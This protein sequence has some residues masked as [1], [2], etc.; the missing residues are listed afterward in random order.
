VTFANRRELALSEQLDENTRLLVWLGVLAVAGVV[1]AIAPLVGALL[2]A[3]ILLGFAVTARS[4]SY[5]A[6]AATVLMLVPLLRLLWVTVP[7]AGVPELDWTLLIAAP[8]AVATNVVARALGVTPQD[9][10]MRRPS[11]PLIEV[12]VVAGLAAAGLVIGLV[13][14]DLVAWGVTDTDRFSIRVI[15][16]A[17]LIAYAEE[18][19]FRGVMPHVLERYAPG[20][21][22]AL[23]GVAY[24]ILALGS[25]SPLWALITVGLAIVTT[26][27]VRRSGSLWGVMAGHAA[28]L[29]L[30]TI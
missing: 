25:G 19:A 8:F 12:L 2:D 9:V 21:G 16:Y 5:W 17:L 4:R 23:A 26:L 27:A 1:G 22:F 13:A 11:D 18:L 10:G 15:P 3:L 24:V 29:I 28:F 6:D 7:I 30:L 20:L 14:G